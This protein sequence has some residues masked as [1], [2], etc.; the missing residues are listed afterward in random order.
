MGQAAA[1]RTEQVFGRQ[2]STLGIIGDEAERLA[3][4]DLGKSIED[5]HRRAA[6]VDRGPRIDAPARDDDAV[7]LLGQQRVDVPALMGGVIARV[8]QEDG[9]LCGIERVLDALEERNAEAAIPVRREQADRATAPAQEALHQI[10]RAV[11]QERGRF[12]D[13]RTRFRAHLT[14]TVERL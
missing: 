4:R 10:V 3:I 13:P 8:A 14:P 11:L 6:H 12:L 5:G 1:A 7:D 9:H 2:P